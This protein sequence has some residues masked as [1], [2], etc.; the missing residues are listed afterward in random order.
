[1]SVLDLN[2]A[3][4]IWFKLLQINSPMVSSLWIVCGYQ[5]SEP[6]RLHLALLL[7]CYLLYLTYV[8]QVRR[9]LIKAIPLMLITIPPFANYLVFV[10]M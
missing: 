5:H 4:Y 10:L 9:D 1:M 8:L 6:I 7:F 2:L 3:L